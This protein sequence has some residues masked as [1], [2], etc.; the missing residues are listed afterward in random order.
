[1]KVSILK[2]SLMME[3]DQIIKRNRSLKV[4]G[5]YCL[6][7]KL[8]SKLLSN[9]FSGFENITSITYS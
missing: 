3:E 5:G 6:K 4:N 7:I 8:K 1:M 2:K 9:Y